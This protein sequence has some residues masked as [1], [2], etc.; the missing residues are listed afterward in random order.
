MWFP[1]QSQCLD[2]RAINQD[3]IVFST[4]VSG[5]RM[6]RS[7]PSHDDYAEF[8]LS[9]ADGSDFCNEL[10]HK[11][12]H[13]YIDLDSPSNLQ[14][15]GFA[16]EQAFITAFN[17]LISK[18]FLKHLGVALGARDFIWSVSSRPA[19]MSYHIKIVCDHYWT[20]A[21]RK[22]D[23]KDFFKLVDTELVN[24]TGFHYLVSENDHIKLVSILDLSVYSANRCM[25]SLGCKKINHDVRFKPIAGNITR[26]A[27]VQ[28]M[29]TVSAAE[30]QN[31]TPFVLKSKCQLPK[32]NVAIH[33]NILNALASKFGAEYVRTDGSLVI[34]K[35]VGSRVCPIGGET[36]AEDHC[37]LVLKDRGQSVHF[38]C[39]N[40]GCQGKLLKVHDTVS[41]NY[42]YY[43]DY[44]QL[45]NKNSKDLRRSDVEDYL[46]GVVKYVDLPEDPFFV[47]LSKIGL[48]CFN[49][50]ISC[51][52]VSCSKTLFHRYSDIHL[53][54]D[55]PGEDEPEVIKFSNVLNGMLKRRKIP[56]YRNVV[57]HPYLRKNMSPLI[58]ANKYNLFQ[59]FAL[60]DVPSNDLD[61]EK[62]Q[63]H[64][65]LS[66]LCGNDPI[67]IKYLYNFLAAKLQR[68]YIKHPVCLAFI[69]SREG[70]GKGTFSELLKRLFACGENTHVSFNSL[71]SFGNSFNGIQSRALWIVLEEVSARRGGLKEWNGLLKD[72]ISS[73]TLLCEIK[74]KERQQIPFFGNVIIF[75]NE[76]QVLSC[77]K[78][79]RRL[80]FF[81]SDNSMAN[82]KEYFVAL[83]KELDSLP[84]LKCCF[85]YFSNL[86]T[87][88]FN[89]RALPFSHVKEK[90]AQCSEKHVTKFHR[91]LFTEIFF[92]QQS[93]QFSPAELYSCYKDF[94]EQFGIQ[95]QSDRHH[96]CSNLELY[97]HMT[98]S[99]GD[100]VVTDK[101]RKKYLKEMC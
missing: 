42:Q 60:E 97:V 35:T 44:T 16:S 64:D 100:Y 94:V 3:E 88:E 48:E 52:Q 79:D 15:L 22:T 12:C 33:T 82:N 38:G 66:K 81:S 27:V 37:F 57:W 6:Y 49:H 4:H 76:F 77:S 91:Y 19:K 54:A 5:C 58:P 30:K 39:H 83:W 78:F 28:H 13:T 29:L 56:T 90:L 31:L 67:Y 11:D 72:K 99:E 61:F 46:H 10:L 17:T 87:S 43:E 70:A 73:T 23:M 41:S 74:N 95:K 8:V 18:C 50:Q 63:M 26:S 40:A 68:P 36:N 85:D 32:H 25:R 7:F 24:T 84:H 62:T 1:K 96:V 65:L 89:Y 14:S 75:S 9:N 92:D 55:V 93:Y 101:D 86:D 20:P 2:Q 34:L 45:V 98:R 59:G 69:N 21:Q 71:T 51:D 53:I 47:T 80:V